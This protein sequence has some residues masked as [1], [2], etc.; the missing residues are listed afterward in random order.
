METIYNRLVTTFVS[1][2]NN[3]NERESLIKPLLFCISILSLIAV[4]FYILSESVTAFIVSIAIVAFCLSIVI[5]Y[6]KLSQLA[7]D[8]D[9]RDIVIDLEEDWR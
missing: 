7:I 6:N 1:R 5:V 4:L 3:T 8:L 9:I 2:S